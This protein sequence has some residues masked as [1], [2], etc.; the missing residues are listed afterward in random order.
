MPLERLISNKLEIS[1]NKIDEISIG[2]DGI[3]HTKKF[4]KL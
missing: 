2:S 3:E 4:K 1:Y